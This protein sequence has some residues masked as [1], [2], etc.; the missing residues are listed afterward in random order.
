[1]VKLVFE[2]PSV[3]LFVVSI[4]LS[5]DL[6]VRFGVNA[7]THL[8]G[9]KFL[10]I[11]APF[12]ALVLG[13]ALA[14]IHVVSLS[15]WASFIGHLLVQASETNGNS[16][17]IRCTHLEIVDDGL[18]YALAAVPWVQVLPRWAHHV[19]LHHTKTHAR[20]IIPFVA[21]WTLFS[22][23]PHFFTRIVTS[24]LSSDKVIIFNDSR[25]GPWLLT[26][27]IVIVGKQGV[28]LISMGALA[29]VPWICNLLIP[30]ADIGSTG[31]ILE[32]LTSLHVPVLARRARAHS[33]LD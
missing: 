9:I 1:M 30:A 10:A 3:A 14:A 13:K 21:R 17:L 27:F 11:S 28:D 25:D 12:F 4:W 22:F 6:I 23:A 5:E 7:G 31:F 20:F 26:I 24:I 2:H 8:G 19:A 29:F 16:R 33:S 18:V 15:L 32:A